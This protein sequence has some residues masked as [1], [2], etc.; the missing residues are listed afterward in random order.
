MHALVHSADVQDRDGGAMLLS[1][2]FGRFPFLGKLFADGAYGAGVSVT[3]W[4]ASRSG[5][6]LEIV[7]R[8]DQA[9][10]FV[11]ATNDGS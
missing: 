7:R 10:G 5:R 3:R 6:T 1:T 2:M 11:V 9:K 8:S 4:R